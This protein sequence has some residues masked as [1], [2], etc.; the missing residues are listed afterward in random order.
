MYVFFSVATHGDSCTV[1][2]NCSVDQFEYCESGSECQCQN[3]Y[4]PYEGLCHKGTCK[5]P[6]LK[7]S[8][9]EH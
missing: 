6:A 7:A 9:S 8:T 2:T 3:G 5:A 1:D 4:R